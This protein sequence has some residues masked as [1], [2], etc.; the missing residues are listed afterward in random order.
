M[1]HL[2]ILSTAFILALSACTGG[3]H[4]STETE[5]DNNIFTGAKGEVKII[6][7]DPGHFHAAL[8]QKTM[9][10]QVDPVVN[11]YAPNGEDV[12]DHLK[13]IEDFNTREQNPTTWEEKVYKGD[14]FFE[15]MIREKPGNVMVTAG[16]N[17]KKTDYIY[18]TIEAGINVLADKPM[19][20]SPEEFPKLE[21]AFQVAKEKGVLLYDIMTERHEITTLLQR[22][23][24]QLPEVFGTLQK[25]S[26]EEPAITKESVH[27]F[28]K[29]VSGKALKRPA[30]FFDTEQQG[31]GI[32]DVNTHLVDLIQWEAF[33]EV[34]LSKEDVEIVS[35][36]R[37]TT[38]LTPEM[39]KK[40][41]YLDD[42]PEY[43][44]K[45]VDGDVLKVYS[46]GEINYTLKGVHAKASVVWNF[47]APEGA[48]DTHYSIMRGTKCNLEII[49]GEKEG[50]KPQLY[51]EATDADPMVFAGSLNNAVT[52]LAETYPGISVKKIG[53]KMWKINIPEKYKV[54]H[55]AHFG[56]VTEKYLQYLIDGKLPDWEI[57][58]MI[59]KYYTTTKGLKAAEL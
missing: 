20:I 54:G 7:L 8:L 28:F 24:S 44:E 1:K 43:L 23:L 49:Q 27:H 32:V 57:P 22:E 59:V 41:T 53:D 36:K 35:A 16:N 52:G 39:F 48:G 21:K 11:V 13:R 5:K 4:K 33:P 38:D 55:E 30:W 31:E 10:D 6:T 26:E 9:Y 45:D 29:Y 37:W 40:V 14:D 50:Y 47:E 12:V 3:S 18:K 42:Y 58:N 46:N 2:S 25:G 34:K 17:A 56:Q 15:K 19:V 51:I